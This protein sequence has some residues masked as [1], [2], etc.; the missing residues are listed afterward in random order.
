MIRI[1]VARM[2]HRGSPLGSVKGWLVGSIIQLEGAVDV[3][4]AATMAVAKLVADH[5]YDGA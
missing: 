1:I 5:N 4:V 3:C 2:G